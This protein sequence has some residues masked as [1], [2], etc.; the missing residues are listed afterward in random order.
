MNQMFQQNIYGTRP[1]DSDYVPELMYQHVQFRRIEKFMRNYI[2]SGHLVQQKMSKDSEKMKHKVL[3]IDQSSF[4]GYV[5]QD[6]ETRVIYKEGTGRF[7]RGKLEDAL[8]NPC[9]YN[10]LLG[11]WSRGIPHGKRIETKMNMRVFPRDYYAGRKK[12]QS[13]SIVHEMKKGIMNGQATIFVNDKR[14]CRTNFSD[15]FEFIKSPNHPVGSD[16]LITTDRAV[17]NCILVLT[18]IISFLLTL[19]YPDLAPLW[20]TLGIV[21][22]SLQLLE[23]YLCQTTKLVK[24]SASWD[25]LNVFR[26]WFSELKKCRPMLKFIYKPSLEQIAVLQEAHYINYEL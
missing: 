9:Y 10:Q 2:D 5:V 21:L 7:D 16:N 13:L 19:V 1:N 23:V 4:Y 12:I 24:Y 26:D 6:E 20:L 11:N 14:V 22:Y 3:Y 15:H 18:T 17:V 8:R 25:D